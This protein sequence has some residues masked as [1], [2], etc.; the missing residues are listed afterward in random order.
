MDMDED[1]PQAGDQEPGSMLSRASSFVQSMFGRAR[2]MFA[3][4]EE[5]PD[6]PYCGGACDDL[7]YI[8]EQ[9]SYGTCSIISIVSLVL[10][11]PCLMDYLRIKNP[12]AHYH[13]KQIELNPDGSFVRSQVEDDVCPFLPRSVW[14]SYF[15]NLEGVDFE[16]S[17]GMDLK[18]QISVMRN[19][20]PRQRFADQNRKTDFLKGFNVEYFMEALFGG[21]GIDYFPFETGKSYRIKI[22][23][24]SQYFRLLESQ[25]PD[26]SN[27]K[28]PVLFKFKPPKNDVKLPLYSTETTTKRL[29]TTQISYKVR[30][31]EVHSEI[32][33][34]ILDL[35]DQFKTHMA[36]QGFYI[37]PYFIIIGEKQN[38]GGDHSL[39]SILG[40]A[41]NRKND[42]TLCSWGECTPNNSAAAE[43]LAKYSLNVLYLVC[44]PRDFNPQSWG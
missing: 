31:L 23:I 19:Y 29:K 9:G 7:Q 39:H 11:T 10:K 5:D 32:K 36:D 22:P 44:V 38:D 14:G 40:R 20:T 43:K 18:G 12:D 6:N 17:E 28:M 37:V 2:S 24:T 27:L 13:L 25:M 41:C 4:P 26:I 16:G 35:Y 30:T 1:L 33:E 34:F 8:P 42:V 15:R 21:S 3:P